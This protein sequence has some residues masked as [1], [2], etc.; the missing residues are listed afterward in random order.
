MKTSSH[1]L[2]HVYDELDDAT[3]VRQLDRETFLLVSGDRRYQLKTHRRGRILQG[4]GETLKHLE[5]AGFSGYVP[6]LPTTDGEPVVQRDGFHWFL[7]PHHP[8]A[9][10]DDPEQL[11]QLAR[12]IASLHRCTAD[13]SGRALVHGAL[14]PEAVRHEPGGEILLDLWEQSYRGEAL[15]DLV[16][17]ILM[18]AE[19][20]ARAAA[21]LICAYNSVN[22]LDEHHLRRLD[23]R[24]GFH[25]IDVPTQPD[26]DPLTEDDEDPGEVVPEDRRDRDALLVRARSAAKE[27]RWT[28]TH[29][30]ASEDACGDRDEGKR[31]TVHEA[32]RDAESEPPGTQAH[33][34]TSCEMQTRAASAGETCVESG[35]RA[36]EAPT[37]ADAEAPQAELPPGEVARDDK[38][39]AE[40]TD[41]ETREPLRW[42][43][44][45]AITAE[46]AEE[47]RPEGEPR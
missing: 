30:R 22:P 4:V 19:D 42:T 25:G 28:V 34:E 35:D 46:P 31:E 36:Q 39:P 44:P 14:C 9:S 17:L 11:Q 1:Y 16:D 27:G 15:G 5:E 3:A 32:G 24:L 45:P 38:P 18:S 21:S 10:L 37:A 23:K 43:F 47:D 2:C 41:A 20:D 29:D 12:T 26:T 40:R 6:I 13:D 7:Q 8:P 33:D